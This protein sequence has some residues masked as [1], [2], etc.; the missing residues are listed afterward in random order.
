MNM[1]HVNE[2]TG[3]SSP[4]H[5]AMF[6]HDTAHLEAESPEFEQGK[7]FFSLEPS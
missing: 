5:Q 4:W 3:F 1:F 7:M 2:Q 6:P